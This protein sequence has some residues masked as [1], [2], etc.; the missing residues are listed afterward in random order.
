MTNGRMVTYLSA[1]SL[2]YKRQ[3]SV[4]VSL[5][6]EDKIELIKESKDPNY[7]ENTIKSVDESIIGHDDV[8]LGIVL[9]LVGAPENKENHFRGRIHG[10]A[11][12]SPGEAKSPLGRIGV[13]IA[14]DKDVYIAAQTTSSI[15]LVGVYSKENYMIVFRLGEMPQVGDGFVVINEIGSYSPEDQKMILDLKEEG[16]TSTVKYGIKMRIYAPITILSITNLQGG[17]WHRDIVSRDQIP[18]RKEILDRDDLIFIFEREKNKAK[19]FEYA[20]IPKKWI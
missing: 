8:K 10:T 13:R 2:E 16:E 6:E 19:K 9:M 14:G 7:I 12:G 11:V 3:E 20:A 17:D 5:T 4:E 1:E 18:L 15:S